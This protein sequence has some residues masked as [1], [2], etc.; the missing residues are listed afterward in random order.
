LLTTFALALVDPS[1]VDRGHRAVSEVLAQLYRGS[2][3]AADEWDVTSA[4]DPVDGGWSAAFVHH[5]GYWSHFDHYA[6]TSVW[7]LPATGSCSELADFANRYSVLADDAPEPG[8]IYLLWSPARKLFV[9]SGIVLS[10]S[11]RLRYASGRKRY[12]CLT[13]DGDTTRHGSLRGPN[14]VVVKRTLSPSAGDLLIRWPL[15]DPMSAAASIV[16]ATVAD[17]RLRRAA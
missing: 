5:V 16:R 13:I 10:T 9:R 17:S 2:V 4:P 11:R 8:D 15:I 1:A 3:R 6:R 14:T 7:P 12:D